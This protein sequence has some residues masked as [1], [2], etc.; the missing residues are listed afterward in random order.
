MSALNV[1][2]I[3]IIFRRIFWFPKHPKRHPQRIHSQQRSERERERK[4]HKEMGKIK[5]LSSHSSKTLLTYNPR[6]Y[7]KSKHLPRKSVLPASQKLI[8]Y[9]HVDKTL[10]PSIKSQFNKFASL[11]DVYSQYAPDDNSS[12]S[13]DFS[14]KL[15]SSSHRKSVLSSSDSEANKSPTEDDS[16][17]NTNLSVLS[18][19]NVDR[20][21]KSSSTESRG[22]I[23][24]G[25]SSPD[26]CPNKKNYKSLTRERRVEANARERSRVHTISAAFESLR[27]AVPGYSNSPKLSKLGILRI[28]CCYIESLNQ[29]LDTT[30]KIDPRLNLDFSKCIQKLAQT[31]ASESKL[32]NNASTLHWDFV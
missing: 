24:Q 4:T 31:I 30:E 8:E 3:I 21:S 17:H 11:E 15:L 9:F 16:V 12:S 5:D 18:H 32:K 29:L 6:T 22:S 26:A 13:T 19:T 7:S 10:L 28:A 23:T 2:K 27:H 1:K 14:V 20:Q 25:K